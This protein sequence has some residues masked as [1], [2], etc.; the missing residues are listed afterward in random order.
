MSWR[1]PGPSGHNNMR[2]LSWKAL[3]GSAANRA[4]DYVVQKEYKNTYESVK[5]QLKGEA[6]GHPN[7]KCNSTSGGPHGTGIVERVHLFPGWAVRRYRTGDENN[8][9]KSVISHHHLICLM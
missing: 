9:G 3:A 8:S 7:W 1:E 5:A 2:G 6:Q 4:K